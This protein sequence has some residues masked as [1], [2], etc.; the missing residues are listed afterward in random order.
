VAEELQK[1]PGLDVESVDGQRGEFTVLVDGREV[2]RKQGD[3]LPP[4]EDVLA[5]VR[6]AAQATA[7]AKG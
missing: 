7:G 6:G 1:M 2:V 5:A 3:A 4:V